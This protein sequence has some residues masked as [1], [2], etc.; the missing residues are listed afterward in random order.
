MVVGHTSIPRRKAL[1][2]WAKRR[3][4]VFRSPGAATG[5]A[6]P[7]EIRPYE[8]VTAASDEMMAESRSFLPSGIGGRLGHGPAGLGQLRALQNEH[9]GPELDGGRRVGI[10]EDGE[11]ARWRAAMKGLEVFIQR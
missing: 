6:S 11:Q 10:V 4:V 5:P 2:F 1:P 3:L 7:V 8:I 9:G